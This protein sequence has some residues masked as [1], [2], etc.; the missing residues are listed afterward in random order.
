MGFFLDALPAGNTDVPTN[1]PGVFK[2]IPK[3]TGP[4][5][6][7]CASILGI[8]CFIP[9]VWLPQEWDDTQRVNWKSDFCQSWKSTEIPFI[10]DI[11]PGYDA[12]IVFPT[13]SPKF[14][15]NNQWMDILTSLVNEFGEDGLVYNSWNGYT[16]AMVA[17]PT[18][19]FGDVHYKWLQSLNLWRDVV[20]DP[21]RDRP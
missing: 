16:E 3:L 10:M 4:Y 1:A 2:P 9:E 8:Q 21:F 17:V 14:G 5:L 7:D 13:T 20:S 11:A 6:K 19:E 12:H 15:L 18:Q